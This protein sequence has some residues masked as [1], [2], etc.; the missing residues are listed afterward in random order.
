MTVVHLNESQMILEPLV[1]LH[2]GS[3]LEIT[4]FEYLFRFVLHL[5]ALGGVAV[6]VLWGTEV[7]SAVRSGVVEKLGG[8]ENNP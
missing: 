4:L 5:F 7:V 3:V 8:R 1:V 6:V 2:G